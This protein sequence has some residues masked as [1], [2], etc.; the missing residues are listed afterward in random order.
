MSSFL[1]QYSHVTCLHLFTL[2][3]IFPMRLTTEHNSPSSLILRPLMFRPKL[4]RFF[5]SSSS[6]FSNCYI[7]LSILFG[8]NIFC[9]FVIFFKIAALLIGFKSPP[10]A[11]KYAFQVFIQV[12]V[13]SRVKVGAQ[14]TS[15]DP[16]VEDNT[17]PSI[18][19]RT[20]SARVSQLF[21]AGPTSPGVTTGLMMPAEILSSALGEIVSLHTQKVQR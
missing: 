3:A 16:T 2:M 12:I 19:W 21:T 9:I 4:A 8:Q 14:G 15:P 1:N 20:Y 11:L 18:G 10:N 17:L 7:H 6:H 13:L 5:H